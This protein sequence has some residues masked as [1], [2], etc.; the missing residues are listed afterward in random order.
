MQNWMFARKFNSCEVFYFF[1]IFKTYYL[2]VKGAKK[3][4]INTAYLIWKDLLI[5]FKLKIIV[6]LPYVKFTLLNLSS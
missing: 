6:D 1:T 2:E 5:I 3:N 4:K